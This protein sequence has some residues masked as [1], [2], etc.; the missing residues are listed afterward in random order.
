MKTDIIAKVKEAVSKTTKKV[1]KISGEAID[2]TKLKLKVAEI[3]SKLDEK[4]AA[5]GLA[6]YEEND[7]ADVETICDEISV[8]KQE[9]DALKLK[10]DEYKNQKTCPACS[11]A[12]DK[13]NTYCPV[14]GIK[15]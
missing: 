8:L 1:V 3:D 4:Y 13:E 14:C 7:E 11:A 10:I 15:F 9:R 5:I 2:Y 6:V 12:T